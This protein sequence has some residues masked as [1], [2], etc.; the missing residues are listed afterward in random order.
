TGVRIGFAGMAPAFS[1]RDL[2]APTPFALI[3]YVAVGAIAGV[4]SVAVTK[5][6]YAVEDVFERLPIH[7][8]WWPA[9]G[10]IP[11]GIIGLF[12]PRTMGVGY[13]HIEQMISGGSTAEALGVLCACELVT[14]PFSRRRRTAGATR[15]PL[16]TVARGAGSAA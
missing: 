2:P 5:A 4:A 12:V 3:G 11:V 6:V 10:A 14:W 1:V 7:W 16:F 8:M 9:L 13:D 15:R